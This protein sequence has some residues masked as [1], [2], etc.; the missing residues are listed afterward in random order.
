ETSAA[1][2]FG[3]LFY[4]ITPSLELS[5]GLRYDHQEINATGTSG[6]YSADEWQP[7]VTL[8]QRWTDNWMTYGSIARGFRGGGANSPGAPNP[9]WEG[10]S[11]WTYELGNKFT[12][13]D[14]TL[15]LNTAV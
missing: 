15:T 4:E 3:T 2:I 5:V 9:I 12:T 1:A 7:R 13:N 8:T 6:I 10:D 14:N 11:V